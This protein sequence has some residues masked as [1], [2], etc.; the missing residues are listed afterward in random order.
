MLEA[1]DDPTSVTQ[2]GD[3][4]V[5]FYNVQGHAPSEQT[6][7]RLQLQLE[8]IRAY[9]PGVVGFQEFHVWSHTNGFKTGLFEMDYVEVPCVFPSTNT[10]KNNYTAIFY[11]A[12]R[13]TLLDHGY[14]LYIGKN[15]SCSKGLQYVVLEN[16]ETKKQFC[17]INTHYWW[18]WRTPED[19]QTR[20]SNSQELLETVATVR[21]SFP[22]IAIVAGG[23]FNCGRKEADDNPIYLLEQNGFSHAF[24]VA[25][26]KDDRYGYIG[27][28]DAFH[29][30]YRTF[31]SCN[32]PS[33]NYFPGSIDHALVMGDLTVNNYHRVLDTY[34]LYSSDHAPHFVDLTIG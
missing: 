26:Q 10:K 11:Q 1:A 21:A 17:V 3:E 23:D 16:R 19:M 24:H 28:N 20:I 4:R 31:L 33:G 9:A 13:Y 6:T 2:S 27:Y 12:S 8:L 25:E 5:M 34:A 7:V 14:R 32:K 22:N 30:T 18:E 15:D 29:A